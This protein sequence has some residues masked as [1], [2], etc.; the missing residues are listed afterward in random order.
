MSLHLVTAPQFS[1]MLGNL[2]RWLDKAVE[3]AASRSFDANVLLQARLAPDQFPLLRQIQVACDTAK[4]S[5]S[6]AT[7]KT[8][9]K[10]PDTEQTVAEL[11]ARIA[12]VRAYLDEFTAADFEG[13]E[14]RVLSPPALQGRSAK[15]VDYVAAFS[16]PN[17]YFHV[18][19]AYAIL[20]HNGVPLGKKDYI[21][22]VKLID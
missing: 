7:G 3:Y 17:F 2:D 6:L 18:S 16:L 10:H 4:I 20:R 9:P 1:N 15:A 14:G 13:A 5:A 22:R 21:G 8:P 11:K 19:M 12:S